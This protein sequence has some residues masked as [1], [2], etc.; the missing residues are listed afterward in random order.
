MHTRSICTALKGTLRRIAAVTLQ[1]EF[2]AL[3]PTQ[4]ALGSYIPPH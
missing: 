3:S 2:L 1:K 4:L